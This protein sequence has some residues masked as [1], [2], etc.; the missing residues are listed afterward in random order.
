VS[1]KCV[2]YCYHRVSTQ[3]LLKILVNKHI[4]NDTKT[5]FFIAL[6]SIFYVAIKDIIKLYSRRLN[7][8]NYVV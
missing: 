7:F 5:L 6:K 8:V 3:F 1:N 2:L 4:N